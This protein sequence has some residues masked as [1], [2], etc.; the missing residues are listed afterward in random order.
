[1]DYI[2][3]NCNVFIVEWLKIVFYVVMS[4]IVRV[5]RTVSIF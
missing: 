2:Q 5:V 4:H 3:L 1:M